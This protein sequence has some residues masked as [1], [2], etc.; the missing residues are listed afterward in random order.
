M[1]NDQN[2]DPQKEVTKVFQNIESGIASGDVNQLADYFSD[3]TYMSL[4]GGHNG[5]CSSNQAY[6]II[7]DYFTL[8]RVI[9]F[10]FTSISARTY[11]ATGVF[12]YESRNRRSAAQVFI[13]LKKVEDRW[14]ISQL[15]IR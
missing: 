6:Y 7:K 9:S 11:Y 4:S 15:T 2:D 14:Q 13:S 5:Y 8:H 3:Q 10:K 1:G 12:S